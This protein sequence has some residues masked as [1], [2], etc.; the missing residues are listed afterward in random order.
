MKIV[1]SHELRPASRAHIPVWIYGGVRAG[2][3]PTLADAYV[4]PRC[5]IGESGTLADIGSERSLFEATGQRV[6]W[7][8]V[9]R[10]AA[11]MTPVV[12]LDGLDELLQAGG[13]DQGDYLERV[14]SFQ[15]REAE[16]G[17]PLCVVVTAR[18]S[19]ADRFRLP[20]DAIVTRLERFDEERIGQWL[21]AW[22][23]VNPGRPVISPALIAPYGALADQ[24]LLLLMLAMHLTGELAPGDISAP[25]TSAQLYEELFGGFLFREVRRRAPGL[26]DTAAG[27]VVDSELDRLGVLA[28]GMFNRRRESTPE[29]DL[30]ADLTI[31]AHARADPDAE[32]CS[33]QDLASRFFFIYEA[34][35]MH[36]SGRAT[37]SYELLHA[38]FEEFLV[39]RLAVRLSAEAAALSNSPDADPRLEPV[40]ALLR[41]VLSFSAL[42][43]RAPVVEFCAGLYGML[44]HEIRDECCRLLGRAFGDALR[45]EPSATIPDYWPSHAAWPARAAAY[46][47]NLL[48]LLV[49]AAEAAVDAAA[50]VGADDTDVAWRRCAPL[51]ESQLTPEEWRSLWGTLRVVAEWADTREDDDRLE[52]DFWFG[53]KTIQVRR[54]DGAPVALW[55]TLPDF[56]DQVAIVEERMPIVSESV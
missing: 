26:N 36:P 10:A 2:Q 8:D 9:C 1:I 24:P 22:N 29:A 41:S 48:L 20:A 16:A 33:A 54:E 17:R 6:A 35:A 23:T 45:L 32:P 14:T 46:S 50:L 47:A 28:F 56:I 7:P 40:L 44:P 37:R 42:C 34:Q 30:D 27:M 55:D 25:Q 4:A 11:G 51:W 43:A 18:V 31:F 12:F 49:I 38:T 13:T 19:V 21:A 39:A 53:Q 5:L 15:A 52:S 3:L